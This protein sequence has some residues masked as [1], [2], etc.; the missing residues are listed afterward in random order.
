MRIEVFQFRK[1]C[2][3]NLISNKVTRKTSNTKEM[4]VEIFANLLSYSKIWK[5]YQRKSISYYHA[6]NLIC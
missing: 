3:D 4:I 1:K 2:Y 5:F 6:Y